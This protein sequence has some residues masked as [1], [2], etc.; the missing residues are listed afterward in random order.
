MTTY[1]L[2]NSIKE[3]TTEIQLSELFK[4]I[5]TSFNNNNLNILNIDEINLKGRLLL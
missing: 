1:N 4:E 3:I 2:Q 5:R